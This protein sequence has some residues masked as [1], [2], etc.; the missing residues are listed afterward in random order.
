M[1]AR[2][3]LN[4]YQLGSYAYSIMSNKI[5]YTKRLDKSHTLVEWESLSSDDFRLLNRVVRNLKEVK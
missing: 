5:S 2:A 4:N 3:I 1:K